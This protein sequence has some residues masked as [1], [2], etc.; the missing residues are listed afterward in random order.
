VA[1]QSVNPSSGA[2]LRTFDPHSDQQ[3]EQMLATAYATFRQRW[4][5]TSIRELD[6]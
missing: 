2:V 3:M 5:K 4:S 6:L 1:Y